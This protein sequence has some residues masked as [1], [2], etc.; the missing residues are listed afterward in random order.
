MKKSP[1][2]PLF[3]LADAEP[4]RKRIVM[5]LFMAVLVAL[6]VL[7]AFQIV[8][9]GS[10]TFSDRRARH[11][12]GKAEKDVADGLPVEAAA[13]YERV[14]GTESVSLNLRIQALERLVPLYNGPLKN[15][16]AGKATQGRLDLFRAA[17]AK[18]TTP[19]AAKPAA[20]AA[21]NPATTVVAR[22]G[23]EDITLDQVIYAWSQS[24]GNRPPKG[25]EF[26]NFCMRY[27]DMVLLADEARRRGL[28]K[29]GQLALDLQLNRLVSMN[30]A[31]AIEIINQLKPPGEQALIDFAQKQWGGEGDPAV[32]LG[33]ILVDDRDKAA[34]A[35]QRLKA[36]EDFAKV[37]AAMSDAARK[38]PDGYKLG[39]VGVKETQIKYFGRRAGLA[40]RLAAYADGAT[41]GPI[42]VEDGWAIVKI[43][44]HKP[45]RI[46]S[47]KG[48]EDQVLQ[49]YQTD[50]VVRMQQDLLQ[51]L[52][53][54]H[55][56]KIMDIDATTSHA[57]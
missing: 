41:T 50:Q 6:A 46:T 49:A 36:G 39:Q 53:K 21:Q 13:L 37:A 44:G 24:Y 56:I 16:A 29:R 33:L 5:K 15:P 48:F 25:P 18:P 9:L 19:A 14:A 57:R 2:Q 35:G 42:R 55:P 10:T 32:D 43:L 45:G 47:I 8:P 38:L 7:A 51:K 4:R 31:M 12:I 23:D 34:E 11:N 52:H 30:K 1:V 3:T 27:F 22:I 17:A 20:P 54:D 26:K 28:D 40:A